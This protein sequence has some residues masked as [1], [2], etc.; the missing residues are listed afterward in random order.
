MPRRTTQGE[1]LP[2]E[3]RSLQQRRL[4]NHGHVN[5]EAIY[6]AEWKQ[7][8]REWRNLLGLILA[9]ED[10][11]RDLLTQQRLPVCVTRRDAV[12]ASTIIQWL[13]TNVGGSFVRRCQQKVEEAFARQTEIGVQRARSRKQS[14]PRT[15]LERAKDRLATVRA[16]LEKANRPAGGEKRQ[17]P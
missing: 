5:P 12:V 6:A 10:G 14:D 3:H 17:T 7:M 11:P 1:L 2:V 15:P 13:G 9:P 4:K 8:N 16:R